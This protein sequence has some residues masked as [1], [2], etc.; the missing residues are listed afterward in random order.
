M[1]DYVCGVEC[2]GGVVGLAEMGIYPVKVSW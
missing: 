2:L 1:T